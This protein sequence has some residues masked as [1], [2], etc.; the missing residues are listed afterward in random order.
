MPTALEVFLVTAVL[1]WSYD[2]GFAFIALGTLA[3]YSVWTFS[4]TEWRT[5]FYRASVEA[6]TR[7]NERAVD[8]LLN[9]ETVKYFNNEAHEAA[10]GK[11]G[12]LS[13]ATPRVL[14]G[15][16]QLPPGIRAHSVPER[17]P[18]APPPAPGARP[19]SGPP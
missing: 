6:D 3:A 5:R 11:Q 17:G 18:S 8:S 19:P 7:A 2:W 13:P 15:A 10:L 14:S 16:G 1:V 9:Y 12:R 4:I